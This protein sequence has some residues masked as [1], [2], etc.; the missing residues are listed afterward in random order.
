MDTIQSLS[1]ADVDFILV[2]LFG[3]GFW[4]KA[5]VEASIVHTSALITPKD[6]RT[7]LGDAFRRKTVSLSLFVFVLGT[8]FIIRGIPGFEESRFM[9]FLIRATAF[10]AFLWNQV[11]CYR[12]RRELRHRLYLVRRG[13]PV[14]GREGIL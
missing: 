1:A 12:F 2:F 3:L 13:F 14:D 6:R 9:V 7:T 4:H 5:W 11:E 8:V 10:L